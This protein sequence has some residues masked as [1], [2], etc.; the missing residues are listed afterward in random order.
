MREAAFI[1]KNR[2][3]WKDYEALVPE[4]GGVVADRLLEV[5]D[6]LVSD[7]AYSRTHYPNS[8]VTSYLNSLSLTFHNEIHKGRMMSLSSVKRFMMYDMP[9]LVYKARHAMYI[10]L[11]VSLVAMLIGVYSALRNPDYV[12]M[13]MGSGYIDMTMRNIENGDPAGVYSSESPMSMF[14]WILWNNASVSLRCFAM[15]VLTSIASAVML[16]MNFVDLGAFG[17]FLHEHGV[18]GDFSLALWFHGTL[19]MSAIVIMAGAGIHMGNGWLFPGTYGRLRSFVNSA[20]EGLQIVF[21]TMPMI[22][23]AAMIEGFLTRHAGSMPEFTVLCIA[24]SLWFVV[25]YYIYLPWRRHRDE[26]KE[27]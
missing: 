20:R 16:F 12:K 9:G 18:L 19:E 13:I 21:G 6:D 25:I 10:S 23:V 8:G 14:L 22:F 24:L 15:G 4:L 3:K 27:G 11:C 26:T 1:R 2:A 17:V 5:Y 7:L